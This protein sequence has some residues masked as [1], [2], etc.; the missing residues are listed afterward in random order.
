SALSS[1]APSSRP[2]LNSRWA[3]P[4]PRASFGSCEPP[5]NTRMTTRTIRSSG[6]KISL[7]MRRVYLRIRRL[8]LARSTPGQPLPGL[9]IALV[10]R[11]T[12][13]RDRIDVGGLGPQHRRRA[14]L[15]RPYGEGV[16]FEVPH[17]VPVGDAGDSLFVETLEQL[18]TAFRCV[19]P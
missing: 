6:P 16:E 5:N 4:R 18:G 11:P 3:E 17:R 2:F 7:S 1:L 13:P 8:Q 15:L 14:L 19:R 12:R 10:G 9:E